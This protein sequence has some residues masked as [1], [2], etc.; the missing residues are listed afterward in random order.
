MI[1][2]A[3]EQALM[4]AMQ[5][6]RRRRHQYL[7][8]E[9]LLYSLMNA[10]EGRDIVLRCDADPDHV[11]S[12]LE[13]F[14]DRDLEEMPGDD[15]VFPEQTVAFERVM[16]R[17]LTHVHYSGRPELD[18]GDLLAA[19]LEE[20]DSH[21]RFALALQGVMELDI[22][23]QVWRS[24]S[25]G[26]W[27]EDP[28]EAS[29]DDFDDLEV[30]EYEEAAESER[31]VR[32]PL[33][34]FTV[35]LNQRARDGRIDPLIGREQEL[36]RTVQV[37]CRRRKNNPI[38]VGE[39][40]VGKTAIAEGLALQI[41]NGKVSA[42]PK[43]TEILR[44]D[45]AAMLAGTRYRGDFEQR[46][47][48]VMSALAKRENAIL[49]IDEIH[50]V[51]G[52]GSSATSTLDASDMLKPVLAS[53]ELRCI[54]STTYEEFKQIFEKD[55]ALTRRFQ[56]IE[57]T[58]PSIKKTV[59]IL[60]GLKTC[61][62]QHHGI[63]YTDSALR[64]AA[65][66]S[67]IHINDR[68]LPDK[69]LDVLDEAA[70]SVRLQPKRKRKTIR[71][72]DIEAVVA[73]IAKIPQRSV[74]SSDRAQL[75]VLESEMKRVVFGQDDAIHVVTTAIK[76]A[77]AGLGNPESPIGNFLFIGP[78]GVGKTEV[79]RQLAAVMGVHFARY[80]MSEYMEKHT[81]ARLIGAPPGYIGF[82]QGGLLTDEIRR[83]PYCVLLLDELE[84]AHPDLFNILLQVMDHATLT[85]NNGKR[86]DFRNVVLVMTSN[87]GARDA[88]AR[89]M[90][91]GER[92]MGG[93]QSTAM[94]AVEKAFAPEFRNRLDAIVPFNALSQ[95]SIERVVD[96]FV[97]EL[98][99]R[100]APQKVRLT[101][102]REARSWLAGQGYDP[103]FGAR[104]LKRL[105]QTEIKDRL[106]DELLFGKLEKGG[107]VRVEL[108]K[109]ALAFVFGDA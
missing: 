81:V 87:V 37:L 95:E 5:E 26:T 109:G 56:K 63:V 92:G 55:R 47:K 64:A 65:E 18:A 15:E 27:S 75:A 46:L 23:T 77:R 50:M 80:D 29:D 74:S 44:L 51:V 96:K 14:F 10:P 57:I 33:E 42:L 52:A 84:K 58:E 79:A 21:A 108:K 53:G 20:N 90:G 39:P 93:G 82:D 7:C 89:S 6:A 67:A 25:A 107:R 48:A 72:V 99:S 66:L 101:L 88:A 45:I 43:D 16:Q 104:P 2:L 60:R 32:N 30:P 41:V 22:P 12:T 35:N 49:F 85:D 28:D 103:K 24:I 91:F 62:E 59:Q 54:G 69:A 73:S 78:T 9:H 106:S 3:I 40:G 94:R 70:A 97:D 8:V 105:I 71:P 38:F 17:A 1:S 4:S 34:T 19:I 36:R 83:H 102:T 11:K 13:H 31:T 61:Y 100:L 86:A 68:Y 98:Q 76:R